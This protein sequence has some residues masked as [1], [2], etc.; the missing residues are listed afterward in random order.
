V[1]VTSRYQGSG[2]AAEG[3]DGQEKNLRGLVLLSD[4][5]DNGTKFSTLELASQLRGTC[6]I[7]AF[8]LGRSTTT[9]KQNDIE[10]TDIRVDPDPIPVKGRLK[11]TGYVNAPGFENSSVSV[12]LWLQEVGAKEP[13]LAATVKQILS[14]T[15][16]NEI[17]VTCDA[18]ETAGDIK[19]TLK[20]QPLDGEVSVLNNEISTFASV[21]KEGVSILWVE[22]KRR[23]ES[24]F[25]IDSL[26]NDPRF[27]LY[28]AVRLNDD[29]PGSDMAS[30]FDLDKRHYDVIVIGDITAKR[31]AAGDPDLF[32]KIS[33]QI[34]ENGTGLLMMGGY[35]TLGGAE[36][37]DWDT[38]GGA[39]LSLLPVTVSREHL[40]IDRKVRM[41]PTRDGLAYLLRL[42][43]QKK[44]QL[45]NRIF[46]PLEGANNLGDVR[47]E[48]PGS[49][50]FAQGEDGEPLLVG[51]VK[52]RGRILVFA[53]DTTWL[54]W[55]RSREAVAAHARFWKQLML[56]LAHQENMDGAVHIALDKRRIV[57]DINERLPFTLKARGKDGQEVK[58]PQFTVKVTGPGKEETD[59]PVTLDGGEYRGYFLK[60]NAP[61]NYRL[62]ASVKGKSADGAELS[63]KPSVAHFL[64][65]AQDRETIRSAAD[66]DL[67][68]KIASASGGQFN[69]ADER[70]LAAL[71][72]ELVSRRDIMPRGKVELW[73]RLAPLSCLRFAWGSGGSLVE[74]QRVSLLPCFRDSA[75]HRMVPTPPMGLGVGNTAEDRQGMPAH[76]ANRSANN[77]CCQSPQ[78]SHDAIG[79]PNGTM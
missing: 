30:W 6:P 31:L 46:D 10:L 4:G 53:G 44:D 26:A 51:T 66:H 12:S 65:Y 15:Q 16:R 78:Q 62:E 39:L 7:F 3:G 5:A 28:Y 24:K 2:L 75:V 69:L 29:K 50:I 14:K 54:A 8:G 79:R 55:R 23:W 34:V 13:K 45:W 48:M 42:D 71:L 58:N 77:R 22:G 32:R 17:V 25:A 20:I 38:N 59:V 40:Q 57:A 11:A 70:K 9:I 56:Y 47:K 43:D 63:A 35:Q 49:T 21:T 37:S 68:G 61:G 76:M 41:Q 60:T 72:E 19:V 67:L 33:I 36:D 1:R 64:G 73:A 74:L 52:D 27:R 18:P